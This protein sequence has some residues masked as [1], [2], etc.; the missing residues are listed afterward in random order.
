VTERGKGKEVADPMEVSDGAGGTFRGQERLLP[1]TIESRKRAVDFIGNM[2]NTQ[3]DDLLEMLSFWQSAK[4][5]GRVGKY[6][7]VAVLALAIAVNQLGDQ[8]VHFFNNLKGH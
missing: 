7:F 4:V 1:H 6:L 3:L 5:L 2:S 8:I